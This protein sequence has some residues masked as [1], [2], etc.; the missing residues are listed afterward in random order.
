MT[1]EHA[2]DGDEGR[3]VVQR[4]LV[5][6][7]GRRRTRHRPRFGS[8]STSLLDDLLTDHLDKGYALA[9]ARRAEAARDAASA[10]AGAGSAVEAGA[11]AR[12][13][14]PHA[15]LAIGLLLVGFVLAAAY[16]GTLRQAPES[17]R[18]RQAL[19]LDVAAGTHAGNELQRRVES[20]TAALVRE[21][22]LALTTSEDGE[23]IAREVQ[24]LESAAALLPV[25][26]P[27]LVV[28]LTDAAPRD[29]LDPATGERLTVPPD[30]NGR[31][32]DR[33]LQNVVNGLWAAGAEAMAIN[34]QRITPTTAI[35]A[36]GEAILVDLVPV[37]SPY[38]IEAIGDPDTLLPRFADGTAARRYVSYVG[39][40]GIEF[41]TRRAGEVRL[42]AG[43]GAE[44]R[45]ARP[46]PTEP[47]QPSGSPAPPPSGPAP[48]PGGS[49][50]PGTAPP[51]AES[52]PRPDSTTA[53]GE[54]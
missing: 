19:V 14:S 26:G 33:D 49:G 36:A 28:E 6:R 13:R 3:S 10:P 12:F 16:R 15:A 47:A 48:A 7:R 11:P 4:A 21:R 52:T 35:R 38:T 42:R 40:Y 23:R 24:R 25:K 39:L 9:A 46:I 44:L 51:P 50:V 37:A 30:D 17:E 34:G 29:R 22:D 41:S 5:A 31:L 1:G 20:L 27:G 32:R 43:S 2:R 54:R 8:M 45:H 53:G 18:A